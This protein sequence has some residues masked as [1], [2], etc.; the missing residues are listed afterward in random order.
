M[1][2]DRVRK[3]GKKISLYEAPDSE[4]EALWIADKVEASLRENQKIASRFSTGPIRNRVRLNERC[5]ATGEKYI[6]VRRV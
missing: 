4:N 3:R 1:A 2:L 6:V 5:G